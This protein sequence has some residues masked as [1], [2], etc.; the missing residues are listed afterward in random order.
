MRK[1]ILIFTI[2]LCLYGNTWAWTATSWSSSCSG[3]TGNSSG[4]KQI[5]VTNDFTAPTSGT[6]NCETHWYYW[7]TW[8]TIQFKNNH[9]ECPP[10]LYAWSI[11]YRSGDT[12]YRVFCKFR[13][14]TAPSLSVTYTNAD[15][16]AYVPGDW[17]NQSV[18]VDITCNDG[19]SGCNMTAKTGWTIGGNTYTRTYTSNTSWTSGTMSVT[20]T[21]WNPSAV[22]NFW[23]INIDTTTPWA[24]T[25]TADDRVNDIWDNDNTTVLIA[26]LDTLGQ[27]STRTNYFCRDDSPS[28]AVINPGCDPNNSNQSAAWDT[29]NLS[30]GTHYFRAKTCTQ[31]WNCSGTT[32]FIVKIDTVSPIIWDVTNLN[33]L[34]LLADSG[35]AY[36][37]SVWLNGGA[38]ITSV[39]HRWE[40]TADNSLGS[41]IIDSTSPWSFNWDIRNVDNYRVANGSRQ[42]MYRITQI[43]DEAW[44]C[45][46]GDQDYF[47]N[48]YADTISIDSSVT[49]NELSS[50]IVADGTA[51]N[52]VVHLQDQ[53][54]NDIIPATGITRTVDIEVLANNA[55]RRDQHNNTGT[56]SALYVGTDTTTIPISSAAQRDLNLRPSTNG[57]YTVP[58]FVYAP[59]NN[60]DPLVPWSATISSIRYDIN[61]WTF[62]VTGDTP[63]NRGV[64]WSTDTIIRASPLYTTDF[65]W[66]IETQGFIEGA[67]QDL[68][69]EVLQANTTTTT[70]N[71]L[72]AEFWDVSPGGDNIDNAR[73]WFSINGDSIWEWNSTWLNTTQLSWDLSTL[74]NRTTL[75][76]QDNPVG[77]TTFSYLASIIKYRIW[78]KL[79]VYPGDIIWKNSYHWAA[80]VNN[81]YQEGIK[82]TWNTSSENTSELTIGQFTDD[83]RILWKLTKSTFRRDINQKAFSVTRNIAASVTNSSN[84]PWNVWNLWNATQWTSSNNNWLRIYGNQVL[85]FR[86]QDVTI[87][88][89][90]IE[91]NKTLLVEGWDVYISGDITGSWLL[92]IIVIDGDILIR[93][94]ITDVHAILYTNRSILSTTN[95]TNKLDGDSSATLLENQLYIRGSLFS[96]NTIGGSRSSTPE[97]PYYVDNSTCDQ[98]EAQSY[99]LNYLRRYYMF[100]DNGDGTA[101][102]SSWVQSTANGQ[103]W[104]ENFPVIIDYNP[105]V[106]QNPPPFFD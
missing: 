98:V 47:H 4:Q 43:C 53:Y 83:I 17:T 94:T 55:L 9:Y 100:D 66:E 6:L 70:L 60:E 26:T 51:K 10:G 34:H 50:S 71:S 36:S 5:P 48:V 52:I 7:G 64:T 76:I 12:Q 42:Y 33:P 72:R 106:Q 15:A 38:P 95:G 41:N 80:W 25:I 40:N 16:T 93:N 88:S 28:H 78:S 103:S 35:R 89:D 61:S 96:E 97:C 92:W 99:D 81:S 105:Q 67:V 22:V 101:N 14:D 58:F 23:S 46:T 44:N 59:T 11:E 49:S 62:I 82:I 90:T 13:D 74:N 29:S 24:P 79:I 45:W 39:R 75:M 57:D 84:G 69:I 63:Q 65:S 20:D 91:W 104:F 18:T 2:L 8:S 73:Y 21:A 3:G 32:T 1:I 102:A 54:G 31:A 68:D 56:D 27:V 87:S 85:F 19:E 77:S 86:W 30:D 37:I